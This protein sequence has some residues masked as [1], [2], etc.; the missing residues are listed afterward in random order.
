VAI[1][2]GHSWWPFMVAIHA[3]RLFGSGLKS[4]L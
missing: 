4:T 1:H 3:V 2:G